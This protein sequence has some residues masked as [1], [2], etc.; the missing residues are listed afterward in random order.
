MSGFGEALTHAVKA[1]TK[2]PLSLSASTDSG[3]PSTELAPGGDAG[4]I[5]AIGLP[6]FNLPVFVRASP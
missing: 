3:S 4:G 2:R 1:V 6:L 5:S